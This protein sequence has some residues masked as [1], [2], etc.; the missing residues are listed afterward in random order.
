MINRKVE[1]VLCHLAGR[2]T[3]G[4][5]YWEKANIAVSQGTS[6]GV[7]SRGLRAAVSR[8]VLSRELTRCLC[9]MGRMASKMPT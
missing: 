5:V 3:S 6:G 7:V 9:T 1:V 8:I 2:K 4:A